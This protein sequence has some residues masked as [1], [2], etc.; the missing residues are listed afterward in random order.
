MAPRRVTPRRRSPPPVVGF[1]GPSGAGKTRLLARLLPELRRRGLRV[2]AVK[3]AGHP[4][5]FDVPGK[6]S[7]VLRRAGALAVAV[8]GPTE[9][10]IF[11][12]PRRGGPRA[13]AA[14]LPPVDLV[15]VEGWREAAIPR[16]EVHR[17]EVDRAFRCAR[18]RG[19]VA[20]VTDEPPPRRLPAFAPDDVAGLADFLCARFRLPARRR[21]ASM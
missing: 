13:L 4:H 9:L 12:P 21:S 7:D 11:G 18:G 19:F 1:T 2:A 8:Q 15:V 14:L 5:G 6:D 20:V 16:V 10:A 17:R 3:H